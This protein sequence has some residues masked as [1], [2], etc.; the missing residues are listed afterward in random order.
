LLTIGNTTSRVNFGGDPGVWVDE[1]S[2]TGV[3]HHWA[4]YLGHRAAELKAAASLL[5]IE[6]VTR[7]CHDLHRHGP[8]PAP[9]L[10]PSLE[11][12]E[13]LPYESIESIHSLNPNPARNLNVEH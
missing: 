3:G 2:Q 6:H 9:G 1:S 5:G 7:R 13:P 8:Q 10:S 4:L 12:R 11:L